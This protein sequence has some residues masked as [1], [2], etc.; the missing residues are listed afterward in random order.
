MGFFGFGGKRAKRNKKRSA[1]RRLSLSMRGLHFEPL[2]QRQL[3]TVTVNPIAGPD[4]NSA[5]NTPSGKDLYVPLVGSDTGQTITYSATSSNPFDDAASES[6]GKAFAP[7][8]WALETTKGDRAQ[9]AAIGAR[10]PTRTAPPA[11]NSTNG[12]HH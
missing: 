3:L 1:P 6:L 8:A 11:E 12:T 10:S 5:Y 9:S 4:P 2:E 7:A